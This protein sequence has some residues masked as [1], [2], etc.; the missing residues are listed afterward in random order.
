MSIVPRSLS[1]QAFEVV[2]ER[3]LSTQIPPLAPIRQELLA[4][5]LG[6]SKIPLREA[7][8]RLEQQGLLASH[9][10]RGF[11]VPALTSNEA[12]EVFALRL[13][14]EPEAAAD[15]SLAADDSEHAAARAALAALENAGTDDAHAVV[16]FNR[17]FHLALVRPGGRQITAQLVE[18][19]QVLAERYVR[20]H[21][22]PAGREA[23]A[24]SE[25]R[26]ILQ[27]WLQRD[28]A[29]VS[30]LLSEHILTTLHDLRVQLEQIGPDEPA[31]TPRRRRRRVAAA[32]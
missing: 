27:A 6:I 26:A 29:L 31:K 5:E 22:E 15:A 3:I 11:F 12:E 23:R 32:D 9:P 18:R 20:K 24:A 13:K 8:G 14:I 2:R 7:L 30:R 4:E 21:L 16:R 19:L 10:N 28:A 1:D 17:S 25:H